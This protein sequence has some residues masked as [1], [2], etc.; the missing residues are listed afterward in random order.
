MINTIQ[1]LN[2][3]KLAKEMPPAPRLSRIGFTIEPIAAGESLEE[4]TSTVNRVILKRNNMH[5]YVVGAGNPAISQ[6]EKQA[7]ERAKANVVDILAKSDREIRP[8]LIFDAKAI[9]EAELSRYLPSGRTSYLAYLVAHDT[10]GYGPISI[11]AEDKQNIEEIEVNAPEA[12]LNIVHT[13]F[14]RCVTN[15]RFSSEVSFRHSINKLICDAEKELSEDTP[16][17]DAQVGDARV[18]AQMRPYAMY[19]AAAT[20]RLGGCK[21]IG[22]MSLLGNG[23]ATAE[24]LAYLWL[25]ID[26]G[27]NI[28]ISGAPASGK[29]TVLSSLFAFVPRTEKTIIVE[30]D[31]NE[32]N[33]E[34]QIYNIVS[35]YGSKY[36]SNVT[37]KEQV[38]NS[39]R[40][41]PDR[42]VIGEIRGEEAREVFAG[43]NLG[44][45][46]IT[47][48]HSSEGGLSIIKKL[49]IK[50]MSVEPRAIGMIDIS[51]YMRHLD[52]KR[53][54]LS[55]IS[56]YKW[57]SRAETDTLGVEIGDGDSVSISKA[58]E[59]GRIE[60]STIG[61]SKIIAAFAK[62]E[63][64]SVKFAL[65]EM[66]DRAKFLKKAASASKSDREFQEK[67]HLYRIGVEK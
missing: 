51:I 21:R 29:T 49:L 11:L 27:A 34:P 2:K 54:V 14:G 66:L 48:M 62:K 7:M 32:L 57:L 36:K 4:V 58:A 35:L 24:I 64:L 5:T 1:L 9:A 20:I 8:T 33:F 10:V 15:M 39:L 50:P 67:I 25:A 30:E 17:I 53:R 45:P 63:G 61:S 12:N 43:A 44:I 55:D 6:G 60:T 56:E 22:L 31:V 37:P 41:R 40:M 26:S 19:G 47:T 28:I 18:H 59:N 13:T 42:L 23:T 38:I 52:L 3:L 46:F 65:K 16:I